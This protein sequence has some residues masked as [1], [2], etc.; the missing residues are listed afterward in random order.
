MEIC[1]VAD[2]L[3]SGLH[4][5]LAILDDGDVVRLISDDEVDDEH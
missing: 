4:A 5:W 2:V 3:R 1:Q